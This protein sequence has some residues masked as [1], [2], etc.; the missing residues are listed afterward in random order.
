MILLPFFCRT[1]IPPPPDLPNIIPLNPAIKTEQPS[2]STVPVAPPPPPP[3]PTVT[4]KIPSMDEMSSNELPSALPGNDDTN[5]DSSGGG[6][7]SF[8]DQLKNFNSSGLRSVK[9]SVD[10]SPA[11]TPKKADEPVNM[12]DALRKRLDD[13]Q[14]AKMG[15]SSGSSSNEKKTKETVKPEVPVSENPSGDGSMA[16]AIQMMLESMRDGMLRTKEESDEDSDEW[17]P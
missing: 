14:R 13:R 6:G 7:L 3:P 9:P 16:H 12:M 17:G 2:V 10:E 15:G 1:D 5:L 11:V 8:L 4:S